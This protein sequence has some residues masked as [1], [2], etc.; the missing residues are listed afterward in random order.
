[1]IKKFCY[2]RIR[3]RATLWHGSE[4]LTRI[5][6]FE[7]FSAGKVS[8]AVKRNDSISGD[9]L[10]RTPLVVLIK[11]KPLSPFY[12]SRR[13]GARFVYPLPLISN[14]FAE[15]TFR[16]TRTCKEIKPCGF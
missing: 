7:E 10:S 13:S 14:Y 4:M 15:T 1:M 12:E 9:V 8:A 11:C 5:W 16:E 3:L 6:A 2:N